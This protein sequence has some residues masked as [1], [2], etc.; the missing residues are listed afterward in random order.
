M[1]TWPVRGPAAK[2]TLTVNIGGN[3]KG[4]VTAEGLT[5][6]QGKM[7]CTGAYDVGASVTITATAAVGYAFNRWAGCDSV[8]DDV[9]HVTMN[10]TRTATAVFSPPPSIYASPMSVH[11]GPVKKGVAAARSVTV[12]NAGGAHLV[13]TTADISGTSDFT[14]T[15]HCAEPLAAGKSCAVSV[16]LTA[17]SYGK[18][19]AQLRITS[20]DEK[21]S[22]FYVDLAGN[23]LPPRIS[24]SSLAVYF[25]AVKTGATSSPRKVTVTNTGLSDLTVSPVALEAAGLF[26]ISQN[27]CTK[28][29]AQNGSCAIFITFS[30]SV[31]DTVST[32]LDIT[33]DDQDPKKAVLKVKL[34][35]KGRL[36]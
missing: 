1:Y 36:H 21:R 29:L 32:Y 14:A 23:A 35:G 16:G 11:F 27:N 28:P 9:C 19:F 7:A 24:V 17:Q 34:S 33:S 4:T 3:K 13:V 31:T 10:V 20:N 26:Q 6:P 2:R 5:C 18:S 12:T 30:P 25:G 8:T 22:T 15:S